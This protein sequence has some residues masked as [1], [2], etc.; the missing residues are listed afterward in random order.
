MDNSPFSADPVAVG[1]HQQGVLVLPYRITSGSRPIGSRFEK[2]GCEIVYRYDPPDT[3]VIIIFRRLI[4]RRGIRNSF[5]PIHWFLGWLAQEV[6]VV[7]R[8]IATAGTPQS[9]ETQGPAPGQLIAFYKR[10]FRAVHLKFEWGK[11]WLQLDLQAYLRE[12]IRV[13][14][15]GA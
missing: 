14:S 8:V 7:T 15:G 13:G 10:H 2:D 6:D 12:R 5:K 11:E 1:L 9:K 4:E 3:V